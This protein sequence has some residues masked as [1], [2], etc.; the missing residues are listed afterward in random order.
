MRLCALLVVVALAP[1]VG[2]QPTVRFDREN[3]RL[4]S[5]TVTAQG[6]AFA[7]TLAMANDNG[8]PDGVLPSSYRRWWHC[9]IGGLRTSGETLHITID[10]AGYTD[11]I[12][13]VWAL[14]TDGVTFGAY[15]RVPTSAT[16]TVSGSQHRFTLQTP[17]GV[18]ALRLAKFFPTRSPRTTRG[19]RA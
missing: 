9:E 15:Q 19:C 1:I 11:V 12:L 16:P 18:R 4:R 3:M 17:T 2:A 7:L 14:S 10:R 13:P 5:A 8:T 6:N